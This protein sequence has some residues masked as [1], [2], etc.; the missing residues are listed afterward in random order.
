MTQVHRYQ[1]H[2]LWEGSTADGP[3][4][5]DRGHQVLTPP[6]HHELRL[7]ADPAFHGDPARSNPEQLLLAAPSSCQ[8]LSFL[9]LAARKGIDD[10]PPVRITH[11]VLRPAIV[12]AAGTDLDDV[13]RLVTEAHHGCYVAN[14]ISSDIT[15]EPSVET[16]PQAQ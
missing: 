1:S 3:V 16:A 8:L 13:H 4:R 15:L 2:L 7:S 6:A 10:D 12:V 5:Y 14:T 9:A 11:I